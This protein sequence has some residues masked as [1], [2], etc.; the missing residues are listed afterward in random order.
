MTNLYSTLAH[1]FASR[2]DA[3]FLRVPGRP[4]LTYRDVDVRSAH[5]AGALRE[6]G[7]V[8]GDRVV[9]QID[10]STD[11]VALY[12]ACL[13]I[14][15][16]FLP[17][18]TAYTSG[19][20]GYF[21][22]D[23]SPAVVV[24]RPE[25][26][27][28][29]SARV[30]ALGTDGDGSFAAA[31]D[32]ATP[33]EGVVQRSP[34]DLAA[35]LY[36]SGTTG[37]SKG[38]MLT[39]ANLE[40]NALALH[41]IWG[42]GPDDVLLHTLPIFHVHGLFVALHCAMLSGNEVIFLPRFDAGEVIEQLPNATVMMGVPTQYTRLLAHQPQIPADRDARRPD[43]PGFD[44]AA[45]RS[46]RLFTSGSAPMTEAVHADF[47]ARTGQQ[48]LERYGMTEAGMITSNPYVGDRVPG[49]V[50]FPLPDVELRVSDDDGNPVPTGET[51]VVE[52]RSPGLFAG[53]WRM[54]EKTAAEYRDGGWFIT[55]DVGSVDAEGRL[56]LEGRSSD[57]II[58]GGYNVYPKEVEMVLD[59]LP[60]VLETG[61]IGV[62]HPDFGEAVVAIVVR[63]GT[64]D[65]TDEQLAASLDGVLA[66]F[67]HPKRYIS[68]DALPRNAMSKVQKAALRADLASLF[69]AT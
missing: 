24:A 26:L 65:V 16:V 14:G 40:S 46:M 15:A 17:L 27:D 3:P 57:M 45:C 21:V 64:V 39:H 47:T 32:R 56:T 2:L 31:T 20:V 22:D 12:L 66:R 33:V 69:D 60:G 62:P 29:L 38:A 54:P 4:A 13:R 48:I 58:S 6:L 37:R 25:T 11:N 8:A 19:E 67:K 41:E 50:G 68:T 7:V 34:D 23:A 49:T 51:G 5:M 30:V 9:V 43:P 35:M 10:K 44:A 1:R 53:Y 28:D 42:F 61:V 36:T 63:D 55:G 59:E 18:N 52:I